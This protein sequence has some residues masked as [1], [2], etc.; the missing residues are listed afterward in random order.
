MSVSITEAELEIMRMLWR[1]K[2]AMTV[3]DF[4]AELEKTKGWNKSTIHTLVYRLREKGAILHL[5]GR[6]VA[7]YEPLVSEDEFILTEAKTVHEKFG[8]AKSLALAMVRN[9]HLTNSDIE[10][11][12]EYF[13]MGSGEK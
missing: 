3:A 12:R 13:D 2:R 5:G 6:S 8:G 11:L 4:R 9:G 7:Q 1:D 10:E